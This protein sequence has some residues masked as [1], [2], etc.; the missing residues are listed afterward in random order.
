M[1]PSAR[2]ATWD[3]ILLQRSQCAIMLST[4]H[5]DE[6]ELL[7]D[8]I[9]IMHRGQ[10]VA[11]GTAEELRHQF[12]SELT[13]VAHF[14][15]GEATASTASALRQRLAEHVAIGRT[16]FPEQ[17]PAKE[18][19]EVHFLVPRNQAAGV[20]AA[21]RVL[22]A[23]TD[24]GVLQVELQSLSLEGV[25]LTALTAAAA[26]DTDQL[27]AAAAAAAIRSPSR[28]SPE[29]EGDDV[30]MLTPTLESGE[31]SV[32]VVPAVAAG[33][34]PE[35]KTASRALILA[36]RLRSL[37]VK[38]WNYMK[39]DR[40]AAIS[41]LILPVVFMYFAMLAAQALPPRTSQPAEMV[42]P[43]MYAN[44]CKG[45]S[46]EVGYAN[47]DGRPSA[48]SLASTYDELLDMRAVQLPP[49]PQTN[50]TDWL[51][52]HPRDW[53]SRI[54][55]IA[56][57]GWQRN[58][59]R[60]AYFEGTTVDH[61]D[62]PRQGQYVKAWFDAEGYPHALAASIN[63][64]NNGILRALTGNPQLVVRTYN[65]PLN[66]SVDARLEEYL[67]SG[68]DI[69]VAIFVIFALSFIPA[70]VLVYLVAERATQVRGF[71][72]LRKTGEGMF[73]LGRG[74]RIVLLLNH[75]QTISRLFLTL[76]HTG[77]APSA[78]V[79]LPADSVL[80]QHLHVGHCGVHGFG[81]PVLCG[82][83]GVFAASLHWEELPSLCGADHLLWYE[84]ESAGRR[85]DQDDKYCTSS[86]PCL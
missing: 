17:S 66:T 68:T 34:L 11:K 86:F 50:L 65:H 59:S 54:N 5:L 18:T 23:A 48:D 16:E 20:P 26:K 70:S 53:Q 83:C 6:A 24:L 57:I 47:F 49:D 58:M 63:Y 60:A 45:V 33:T 9:A 64:A 77:E 15:S 14:K 46:S 75:S 74:S 29:T 10:L 35:S 32:G 8:R 76:S 67:D 38:R 80:G 55:T 22:E 37:L 1:D 43:E 13:L 39:R 51:L 21:L 27:A 73:G 69:S 56:G 81:G 79:G 71:R 31:G 25:F 72:L 36:R 41:M 40:K 61:F 12:G 42:T 84:E 82:V 85:E 7:S 30:A 44:L 52:H 62:T 19:Q 28:T 4:H 2:R 78:G 3:L